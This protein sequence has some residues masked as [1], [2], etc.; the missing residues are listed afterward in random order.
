MVDNVKN[1]GVQIDRHLVWDEHIHFA[2]SKVFSTIRSLKYAKKLVPQ[3]TLCKMYRGIVEPYLR[4]CCSVWGACGGARLQVL[5]KLQIHAARIVTNSS[6]D[7]SASALI[8]TLNWPTVADM[9]RV[10]TACMVDKSINDLA[11]DYLSECLRN[12][13]HALG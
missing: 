7:S 1:L 2:R 11:P 9:I 5:Q 13:G 3:D 4:Y 12:T 8:K 10:E 6:Y